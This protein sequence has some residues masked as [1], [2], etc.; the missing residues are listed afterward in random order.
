MSNFAI[1]RTGKL[2]SA[3]AVRGMLSHNFRDIDTPNADPKKTDSNQHL[4]AKSV[5]D[6]MRLY[7]ENLPDKVRKNAVHA[8]DYMIT[9][10]PDATEKDKAD[11]IDTAYNWLCEKHGKENIIMASKHVDETTP[12]IHIL[13]MPIDEKGKLNAYHFIGGSKHRMSELQDEFY[14]KLKEKN[15]GL[16]RGIKGSKA[17]HQTIKA[18]HA[19]NKQIEQTTT[20]KLKTNIQDSLKPKKHST[21]KSESKTEAAIRTVNALSDVVVNQQRKLHQVT[22]K[23][24]TQD[25]TIKHVSGRAAKFDE[26]ERQVRSGNTDALTEKLEQAQKIKDQK[27]RL[28]L[29]RQAQRD[30]DLSR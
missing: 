1:L 12:H 4:A 16:R 5:E 19:K 29:E 30:S 22:A 18:W 11:C 13:A 24:K 25:Q 2:K 20:D 10:S 3:A 21:F 26:L 7:R 27:E 23:L 28:K 9:T 14:A 17:K 6:G 15:I 8:I